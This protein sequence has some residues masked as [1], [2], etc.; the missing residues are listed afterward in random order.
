MYIILFKTPP[1]ILYACVIL[2]IYFLD[3]N[4]RIT[5]QS[6]ILSKYLTPITT[7]IDGVLHLATVRYSSE[8]W[9]MIPCTT[10]YGYLFYKK[11]E[12]I[13]KELDG[14][15]MKQD[16]YKDVLPSLPP[17]SR[18]ITE[19]ACSDKTNVGKVYVWDEKCRLWIPIENLRR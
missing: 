6:R 19:F 10:E 16:R 15:T 14:L 13:V 1:I 5:H 7:I 11:G 9:I 12:F 17:S 8:K 18:I 2:F 4:A 3:L